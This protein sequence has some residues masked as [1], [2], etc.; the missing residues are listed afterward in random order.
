[1]KSRFLLSLFVLGA[2]LGA[3]SSAET[4]WMNTENNNTT[5]DEVKGSDYE[6][7][8]VKE[9]STI[10]KITANPAVNFI[11]VQ[12]NLTVNSDVETNQINVNQYNGAD[13]LNVNGNLTVNGAL[14]VT[15]TNAVNVTGTT[16]LGGNAVSQLDGTAKLT[17]DKL[18]INCQTKLTAGGHIVANEVEVNHTLSPLDGSTISSAS[19]EPATLTVK[20]GGHVWQQGCTITMATVVDGG[21]MTMYRGSFD[22]LELKEGTLNVN[23]DIA[24]GALTLNGGEVIFYEGASLDLGGES[25]VL[26]DNVTITI[27]AS[28]LDAI[29]S[30]DYVLFTNVEGIEGADLTI[31]VDAGDAGTSTVKLAMAQNGSVVVVVPE[32]ATATLSLLALCGLAARRRRK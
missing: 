30:Q 15:G 31:N 16:T 18:I 6:T 25:L 2:A 29:V 27:K 11:N 1:M 28:S 22:S 24:T 7:I 14:N 20:E 4:L 12:A 9:D 5:L 10:G 26:S 21:Q 8:I 32:P 13:S 19:G 23:G 17:T 3:Q